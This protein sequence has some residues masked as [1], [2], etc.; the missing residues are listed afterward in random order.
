MKNKTLFLSL[1]LVSAFTLASSGQIGNMIRNKASQAVGNIGKAVKK[2]TQKE[3]DSIAQAKAEQAVNQKAEGAG[4]NREQKGLNLGGL[5]ANKVDLKYEQAYS[6]SNS[7]YMQAEMYD[8]KD[9][10]KMDYYIYYNDNNSSGGFE[11]K[12]NVQT[13]EG[14]GAV[15][16]SI[17]YDNANKC[18][19]LLMDMGEGKF[20][21]ISAV[22]DEQEGAQTGD[23]TTK[24]EF[25][26]TGNTRVIAGYRCD[27]YLY[28]EPDVKGYNKMWITRDLKVSADRRTMSRSGMPAYYANNAF[29]DGATLAMETYDEKNVLTMKMETKEIRKNINYTIGIAGYPLRQVNLNQMQAQQPK[30]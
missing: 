12:M 26:K 30:K 25:T 22:P 29:L 14:S 17:V 9:V 28:R 11:S 24:G 7:I 4:E 2:E 23:V 1:I 13:D 20:G 16:T 6:F 18:M 10:L 21:M 5:L 8:K 3:A 27:E 15:K 19:L